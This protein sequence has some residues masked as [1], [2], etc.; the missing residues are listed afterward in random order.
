MIDSKNPIFYIPTLD[1]TAGIFNIL[2][3]RHRLGLYR[4]FDINGLVYV[5]KEGVKKIENLGGQRFCEYT[6]EADSAKEVAD[7][8][9][10]VADSDIE[11]SVGPLIWNKAKFAVSTNNNNI[12]PELTNYMD[13]IKYKKAVKYLKT[14]SV[15]EP[16]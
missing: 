10:E 5:N 8:A 13:K 2:D 9:K 12:P 3:G 6:R 7:S 4:Y 14:I 15:M 16:I 1:Y 11:E